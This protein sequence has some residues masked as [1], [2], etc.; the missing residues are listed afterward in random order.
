MP[1]L[2]ENPTAT[3]IALDVAPEFTATLELDAV[4]TPASGAFG[5]PPPN[6]DATSGPGD[7]A[8]SAAPSIAASTADDSLP[9][10]ANTATPVTFT[11]TPTNSPT[12]TATPTPTITPTPI[13]GETAVL[14]L[15][16]S[17]IW[18]RRSPGG[19]NLVV[20][21]D[22][23]LVILHTGRANRAGIFWREVATGNGTIGW[24]EEQFLQFGVRG[25]FVDD[26]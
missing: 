4:Q 11:P 24:V 3:E 26:N 9:I 8:I 12:A 7:N 13:D 15:G 19:Q 2:A 14:D 20:L 21:Q 1:P 6:Q 25:F 5:G 10:V 23:E 22:Q 18:L 16:G 17:V